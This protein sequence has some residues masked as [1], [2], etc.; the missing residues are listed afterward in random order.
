MNRRE[1]IFAAGAWGALASA[2]TWGQAPRI[3]RIGVLNGGPTPT[4][5]LPALDE[6]R[7]RLAKLGWSESANLE[8]EVWFA[9]NRVDR[10]AG[11]VREAVARK[12]EVIVINSTPG[13]LVAKELSMGVPVVFAQLG[14]PVGS[15]LVASLARP[16]GHVTGTSIQM[17][18][19]AGKQIE[20]LK[21]LVP[22]LE[23]IAELR[24]PAVGKLAFDV[25]AR[26]ASAAARAGV[27]LT[28]L[29]ADSAADIEPAFAA[30]ARARIRAMVVVPIGLYFSE[31]KRIVQLA[32]QHRIATMFSSRSLVA[33][34]GLASYGPDFVD[35]FAR[36]APY[37]DKILRGAKPADLP[38]ELAE[39]FELVVNRKA[40]AELGL[41][42]PQSVLVQ[43][44]EVIE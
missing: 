26:L 13:A 37:V 21:A 39:R 33:A 22:K 35:S 2:R 25:S 4:G 43:A 24:S 29:D 17:T 28:H 19:I 18:E 5:R 32:K 1:L 38:V 10:F 44:T 30:A 14:D 3:R 15:G 41:T 20:L 27:G 34:G 9:E 11:L 16:G 7:A 42:I 23:R 40:A 31:I 6:F 36:A 12:V 8:I